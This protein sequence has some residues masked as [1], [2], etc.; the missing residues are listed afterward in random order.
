MDPGFLIP[1]A[2]AVIAF[3]VVIARAAHLAAAWRDAVRCAGLTNVREKSIFGVLTELHGDADGLG[4]TLKT[5]RRG[6]YDRGTR[7]TVDGR[8]Q[9]PVSL[10]LRAEGLYSNVD[11][12]FGGKEL[13]VGDPSFDAEVYAQG[14]EDE[15]LPLLDNDTREAVRGVV[16]LRGQI[17]DGT[18]RTDIRGY[19]NPNAL[20][21]A[22]AKLL[23]AA[24][25]L[26]R[27]EDV[28]ERLIKIASDD[29]YPGVRVR[30]L[31]LLRREHA[32]DERARA[33]FR[34]ALRSADTENRLVGAI[35]L[36]DEGRTA[37][38]EIASHPDTEEPLAVRAI[39]ALGAKLPPDR[40]ASIL[41]TALQKERNAL[42]LA[43]IGALALAGE[44]LAVSRLASLLAGNAADLAVAAARALASIGDVSA[45]APLIAALS[46][47]QGDLRIS[48]ANA[49]G[50]LGTAASVAPLHAA[51]DTHLLDLGL[52]STAH[53]AIAAIQ[54]RLPGA[55]PGQ[56]SLA[57]GESGQL[58]LVHE[59][60][61]GRLSIADK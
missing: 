6:K 19:A 37:L 60:D 17:V 48:A 43:A 59:A 45:E 7:I 20:D 61:S 32:A 13:Q 30:C 26:R 47:D 34:S 21:S 18:V 33:A 38:I 42:A 24:Q 39:T 41:D 16:A 58:A 22:L 49:L 11:R 36:A 27:P 35:A 3:S 40:A 9:I 8:G 29:H 1:I 5:Y 2:G 53:Q 12:T 10:H 46:S 28:V 50:R 51:V 23:R 31:D 25:R 4:V 56:V 57:E 55:S 52:R 54:S 14:P 15:L 44:A